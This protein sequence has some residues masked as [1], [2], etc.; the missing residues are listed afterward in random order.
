[1]H[2]GSWILLTNIG[3]LAR[4][5]LIQVALSPL[6]GV[7]HVHSLY[8][9]IELQGCFSL[10]PGADA[11]CLDPAEWQL[12]LAAHRPG[13]DVGNSGLDLIDKAENLLGVVCKDRG[14][15]P[16][17]DVI[18][19]FQRFFKSADSQDRKYG[20][21]ELLLRDLHFR[22]HVIEDRGSDKVPAVAVP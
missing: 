18:R 21:E 5:S 15:E 12:R 8:L 3:T 1:M 19:H 7:I 2:S 14:C 17:A 11:G 20:A 10:L 16:E 13:I 22:L 4:I 6:S 9:R